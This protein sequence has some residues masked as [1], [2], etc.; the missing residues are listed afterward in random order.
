[1]QL[2]KQ[3][4]ILQIIVLVAV[5]VAFLPGYAQAGSRTDQGRQNQ[6]ST[7]SG[8]AAANVPANEPHNARYI[9]GNDDLLA[10]SVWNEKDISRSVP[11]RPDGKISLPLVGEVEAAGRTPLQLEQ[12]ITTRLRNYITAPQVSVIV[13]K[14]NSEKFNI[15]GEVLKPGS[16][17][18]SLASTVVDAIAL[19]GGFRDFAKKKDI[20]ILRQ[21][22]DGSQSRLSFNY[23]DFVKGK[24]PSQNVHIEPNDTIIV[25]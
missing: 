8:V 19:A 20:H 12:E 23:N 6:A 17:S 4:S 18:T 13:E 11:V 9:I 15:L 5:L 22:A 1:M 14:I 25:P 10:I 3:S 2:K 24:N 16:Y 7:S 21:N